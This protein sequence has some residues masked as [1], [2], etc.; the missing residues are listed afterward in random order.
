MSIRT[1]TATMVIACCLGMS[2]VVAPTA[3]AGS[4]PSSSPA[5]QQLTNAYP[6]GPQRLCC[7]GQAGVNGQ[8]GS[9]AQSASNPQTRPTTGPGSQ[10]T[11]SASR[12]GQTQPT[13]KPTPGQSSGGLA[14][15]LLIGFG[16]GAALLIVGV[17]A[18]LRTR[19]ASRPL[20]APGSSGL[21]VVA[22][23]NGPSS[24]ARLAAGTPK[25]PGARFSWD[26]TPSGVSG[27]PGPS[28][29]EYRRLDESGD[30]GG[31][32][33]LGVVLHQR[34]EYADAIAAYER[35]EQ[36]GDPDAGFN[37]GVLLY[38]SGDLEGAE[39][40]WRRA[41]GRGHVRA[42]ANLVFVSRR[43][44][45]VERGGV[46]PSE[47][48]ELADL[49]ELSYWRADQTDIAG[50][51]YNLGVMLHQRGDISGAMAA[52]ERAE[53]RGDPDAAFN[54]GVLLYD[55]GDPDGAEAAWR[56]ASARGHVQATENLDFLHR[57]HRNEPQRAGV[58]GEGGD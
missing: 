26:R 34:G 55:A 1:N 5:P 14:A 47:T 17:A 22:H 50:G 35:A 36:R 29:L 46:T 21:P 41:A 2:G 8:T 58:A 13:A 23:V 9:N 40:A 37:L 15:V 42:A 27:A 20:P 31:A 57:R 43:R 53:Q 25:R 16:A 7:N 33:N 24:A 52:Y 44:G 11:T 45:G 4:K 39:A 30:A 32:F 49:E 48:S 3:T 18:V 19:R 56:R 6:I 54:L 12:H 28:E 51:A 10:A 38:E